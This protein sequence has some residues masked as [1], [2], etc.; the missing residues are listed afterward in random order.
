MTA[1]RI[2]IV[3]DSED[4]RNI[5]S[6][7]LRHFGYD[8]MIAA[9]GFAALEMVARQ[10]P[11]A[12]VTDLH[13]PGLSG[14]EFASKIRDSLGSADVPI[15][16][17]SAFCDSYPKARFEALGIQMCQQKPVT[18]SKLREI[19]KSLIRASQE[20]QQPG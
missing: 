3:D 7:L 4:D 10:R 11:D 2:L 9:D 5:L 17:L 14:F 16:V 18:P 1:E 19:L 15:L 8:V 12:I 13:M 6:T 20:P